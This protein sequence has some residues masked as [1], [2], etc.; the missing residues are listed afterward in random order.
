MSKLRPYQREGIAGVGEDWERGT[1]RPALLMAT[2]LGKTV[3]LSNVARLATKWTGFDRDA[4][5]A[6]RST[7]S[8]EF[9]GVALILVHRQELVDQT[10]AKL[11]DEDPSLRIGV[12]KAER[13]EYD[14]VDVIVASVA[15]LGRKNRRERLSPTLVNLVIVDECHHAA[16]DSYVNI[17]EYFGCFKV[18][19]SGR[20][21]EVEYP[22]RALGVTAT[23]SRQDSRGLGEVW[24]KISLEKDILF[25]ITHTGDDVER[26]TDQGDGYLCDV[27]AQT[28]F[29]DG[30]DLTEVARSQGDFQAGSLGEALVEVGAA[31]AVVK[32][33]IEHAMGRRAILFAPTVPTAHLFAAE[34]V[35][36]GISTE[37][38]TAV[39]TREE[40]KAIF[41]RFKSGETLIISSV[42]VLTE[43]FDAPWAEVAIICRPTSSQGLYIQMVGRI[44]RQSKATGKLKGL[45][46]DMVGAVKRH[47]LC[48]IA[49]LSK[50]KV[51]P[52]ESLL[53]AVKREKV[54]ESKKLVMVGALEGKPEFEET[55]PFHTGQGAWLKT[56]K[57]VKFLRTSTSLYFVW[58]EMD[59]NT[60]K[61][62][63]C[64]INTAKGG[65]W[66]VSGLTERQAS[67]QCETYAIQAD[68]SIASRNSP[69][70]KKKADKFSD[71]FKR[72]AENKGIEYDDNS[73]AGE[74]SDAIAV[75]NASKILDANIR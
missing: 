34:F 38:I 40:R 60:F 55:D 73:R 23:M 74:V 29:I 18:G 16:A 75:K 37:V 39:T 70:R 65:K 57:G 11:H 42:G 36:A 19:K 12:I 10:I 62:G 35:G 21:V 6:L 51:K 48:S 8:G 2:G 47:K 63:R 58:H 71:N 46:L 61:V 54:G 24:Q 7:W 32:G 59:T 53:E 20:I 67:E 3:I 69:W 28:L 43:G 33:Y 66:L 26:E 22:T 50:A 45:I 56:N 27:E 13:D 17:M 64:P 72:M 4:L 5:P 31:E 9:Q 52:G 49:D 30:L 14:D 44:L 15:T 68:P 25:G 1:F 41:A